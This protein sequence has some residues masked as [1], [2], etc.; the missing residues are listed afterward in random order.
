LERT[1]E[2]EPLGQ[3]LMRTLAPGHAAEVDLT[4]IELADAVHALRTMTEEI[5]KL[6]SQIVN[7]VLTSELLT[8]DSSG[9]AVREFRVP[10]GSVAIANHSAADVVVHA[11][12]SMG[13][14]P[15][16]G[17][18]I[19]RVPAGTERTINLAHHM[20][21]LFGAP[22]ASISLEVFTKAQPPTSGAV[23]TDIQAGSSTLSSVAGSASAVQ[24]LAANPSRRGAVFFN[25]STAVLY[26]GFCPVASVTTANYTVQ[27]AA[28]G[29]FEMPEPIYTGVISGVWAAANGAVRITELV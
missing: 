15:G 19:H 6:R 11:G 3:S 16:T 7:D 22:G 14:T 20:L 25:D 9:L 1:P 18:G 27:I 17:R 29:Y 12:G 4:R 21:T 24:L 10:F 8:L 13:A 5:G 23:M 26:L 2:R 28:G